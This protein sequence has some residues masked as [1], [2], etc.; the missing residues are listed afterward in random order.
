MTTT[1]PEV[2]GYVGGRCKPNRHGFDTRSYRQ[3]KVFWPTLRIFTLILIHMVALSCIATFQS[4]TPKI[5]AAG[6]LLILFCRIFLIGHDACHGSYVG[7]N[8]I[9][10]IIGVWSMFF[11]FHVPMLWVHSHNRMHHG[12]TNLRGKDFVWVPMS[13]ADYRNLAC[14]ER[15]LNRVYRHHSALGIGLYYL[16]EIWAKRMLWPRATVIGRKVTVRDRRSA[17][18]HH[19]IHLATCVA[20][21]IVTNLSFRG[22][23]CTTSE[24]VLSAVCYPIIPI[25]GL[26]YAIGFVVFFNHTHPMIHWYD[27]EEE[28][29]LRNSPMHTTQRLQM[30]G[31]LGYILPSH[32][33]NHVTHH[34]DPIVPLTK[35]REA[36]SKL[37]R[38]YPIITETWSPATHMKIMKTCKLYDFSTHQ[39]LPFPPRVCPPPRSDISI[40][41]KS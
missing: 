31:C 32:I 28:W 40:R 37:A 24:A 16:I 21:V 38:L 5:I 29:T 14:F 6:I 19:V 39:W 3:E 4:A 10:R 25:V 26:S 41:E 36:E 33:M 34:L 30:K 7:S 13:L 18:F 8:K 27:N 17:C 15:W 35:L 9:N 12:F 23:L 2:P 11:V 22:Q 20:I 1:L